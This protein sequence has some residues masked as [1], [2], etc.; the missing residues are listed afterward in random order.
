[1]I[2]FKCIN[3]KCTTGQ[4]NSIAERHEEHLVQQ[5]M[6][7]IVNDHILSHKRATHILQAMRL[8]HLRL[9]TATCIGLPE[10]V[11]D[12]AFFEA[13]QRLIACSLVWP[14]AER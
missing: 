1:V 10:L 13:A 7:A 8:L 14:A 12:N 2:T 9:C 4:E 3:E 5:Q 11:N 6:C